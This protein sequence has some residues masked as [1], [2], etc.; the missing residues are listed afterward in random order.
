MK[1]S[2]FLLS[3]LILICSLYINANAQSS[4]WATY[5]GKALEARENG[6]LVNAEKLLRVALLE[7]ERAVLDKEEKANGMLCDTLGSLSAVVGEQDKYAESEEFARRAVIVSELIYK[8][9]DPDYS[10]ILNNLGLALSNQKKYAEAETIHRRAM[11]IREKYEPSPKRNLM[12]SVL[13]LG[14]V[15]FQQEKY[16]E[17]K[18]LFGQ[19][20]D[21]YFGLPSNE[22][23]SEDYSKLLRAMN[24]VAVSEEKLNELG[25]ALKHNQ[26]IIT[27]IEVAEGKNSQTLIG[28]LEIRVRIL[29]L[30]KQS[31]AVLQIEN[32]IKNLKKLSK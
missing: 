8:E 12:V 3:L 2:H 7:A 29:R 10:R 30:K 20:V 16:L 13:N 32:R 26:T 9:S 18:A 27:M 17:A 19:V 5:F 22:I 21:F 24:N 23:D 4:V 15:Y 6:D 25:E 11:K 28:Y 14:L 1:T 31:R